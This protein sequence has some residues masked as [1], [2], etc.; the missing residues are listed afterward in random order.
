ML[1]ELVAIKILDNYRLYVEF[2]DGRKG[3]FDVTPYLDKGIFCELKDPAYFAK[4]Y[5]SYGT[6]TWPNEQD[7]APE[8]IAYE[9]QSAKAA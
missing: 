4:A 3:I 5:L 8:T 7:F 1:E 6:V 2:D 9:L